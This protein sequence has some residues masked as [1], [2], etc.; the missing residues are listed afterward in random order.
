MSDLKCPWPGCG[1]EVTIHSTGVDDRV[2]WW[3]CQSPTCE[4][5]GPARPSEAEAVA[6][7]GAVISTEGRKEIGPEAILMAATLNNGLSLIA[8]PLIAAVTCRKAV[9]TNDEEA[10]EGVR[11]LAALI[12]AGEKD[13]DG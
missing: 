6:N 8:A 11:R 9:T 13:P 4:A 5:Q 12:T 3:V 7:C 10:L 2:W 1:G